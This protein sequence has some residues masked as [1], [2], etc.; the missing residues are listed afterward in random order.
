M[1]IQMIE[2]IINNQALN[3][4][5]AVKGDSQSIESFFEQLEQAIGNLEESITIPTEENPLAESIEE[6]E[7]AKLEV[8]PSQEENHLPKEEEEVQ[9]ELSLIPGWVPPVI[10]EEIPQE[11]IHS[12]EESSFESVEEAFKPLVWLDQT[13][14]NPLKELTTTPIEDLH[15]ETEAM[16]EMDVNLLS[17]ELKVKEFVEPMTWI[18]DMEGMSLPELEEGT[19]LQLEWEIS[20]DESDSL[21]TKTEVSFKNENETGESFLSKGW[22]EQSLMNQAQELGVKAPDGGVNQ[23]IQSLLEQL[24]PKTPQAQGI[25]ELNQVVET[26]KP[27]VEIPWNQREQLVSQIM[28]QTSV[29]K[30]GET[31]KLSLTLV[32]KHLGTMQ[33]E[34]EMVQ[35]QLRGKIVTQSEEVAQ[36][37]ERAIQSLSSETL[38]LK[39]VQVETQNETASYLF[40]RNQRHSQQESEQQAK[41][42]LTS[43]KRMNQVTAEEDVLMTTRE[44]DPAVR[45]IL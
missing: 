18:S 19:S 12:G 38:S 45:L 37:M 4:S 13:Q 1:S 30:E 43:I 42:K 7:S 23:R 34:F 20:S 32:P 40:D 31:A 10:E 26:Q 27:T 3:S 24:A 28:N 36:W 6:E 22:S 5:T 21:L 9:E 17:E 16:T 39:T 33:L 8:L 11:F 14:P 29:L 2:N 35:G 44:T 41:S 15:I 25:F